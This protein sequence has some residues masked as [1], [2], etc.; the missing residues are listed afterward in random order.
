M[1][2]F[3]RNILA[4]VCLSISILGLCALVSF[5]VHKESDTN[6]RVGWPF[7]FYYQFAVRTENGYE[8]QHGYNGKNFIYDSGLSL[9]FIAI[10]FLIFK[11]TRE[12]F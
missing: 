4:I 3:S 5:F 2:R 11:K 8:I 7:N 1:T 10:I 9:L 6:F 12:S